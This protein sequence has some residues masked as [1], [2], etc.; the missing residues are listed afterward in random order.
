MRAVIVLTAALALALVA[1]PAVA[2]PDTG[3]ASHENQL[4]AQHTTRTY[5][6]TTDRRGETYADYHE[7]VHSVEEILADRRGWWRAG[8]DI[9]RVDSG[10]DFTVILASPQEVD[11]A[12]E[13][14]SP[15][16]S[17]RVGDE[18]Y[19]ND[20]NWR[21]GTEAWTASIG[22]YRQYLVT[23]E[24]GHWL[25]LG[26]YDCPGQGQRA[27]VMQQQ[28]IDMQG[29]VENSWPLDWEIEEAASIH[30]T[31][32]REPRRS[33]PAW[34]LKYGLGGGTADVVFRYGDPG[35]VPVVGNW[36]GDN[37]TAGVVRGN[38]WL[39]RDYHSGGSANY[40]F[41][42]GRSGDIPVVGDW[43]GDGQHTPGVVRGN[44]WYLRNHL[45]GGAADITFAYGHAD[46]VPV[47]GD[48]DGDG[49]DDPG[50]RRG[51]TWL[52]RDTQDSGA[53]D[54]SFTYGRPDDIPVVGNWNATGPDGIGVVRGRTWFLR[55]APSGGPTHRSFAYG[56]SGDIPIV[57]DWTANQ[58]STPG[59]VRG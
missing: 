2:S 28:S 9:V 39:L 58:Q 57:G 55:D 7:F 43:D 45:R 25:G 4:R 36:K 16:Y 27:P 20:H 49:D 29:C 44:V 52:L 33:S 24:V 10:G 6:F 34:H 8:L 41:R 47:V 21:N 12:H 19:I 5:T 56:R 22:S 26:H 37:E 31:D 17:C 53:A 51:R 18:V 1:V 11:N 42:Y 40:E 38:L 32:T 14:C 48:W 3:Q 15:E 59:I 23:H 54:R 46:D 50:V 35:D 30:G 13:V